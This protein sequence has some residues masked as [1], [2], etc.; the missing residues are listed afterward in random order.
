MFE[1]CDIMGEF[2]S[3]LFTSMELLLTHLNFQ[4]TSSSCNGEEP[5]MNGFCEEKLKK[6]HISKEK[7]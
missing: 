3:S 1:K 7:D 4:Q 6:S 5:L 2:S